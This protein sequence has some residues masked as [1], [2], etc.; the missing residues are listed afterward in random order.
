MIEARG[1]F[2]EATR[3]NFNIESNAKDGGSFILHPRALIFMFIVRITSGMGNAIPIFASS[4]VELSQDTW[5]SLSDALTVSDSDGDLVQSIRFENTDT[6]TLSYSVSM[7]GYLENNITHELPSLED[8]YVKSSNNYVEEAIRI[9]LYDG[10]EWG[11]WTTFNLRNGATTTNIQ[12]RKQSIQ[13][14]KRNDVMVLKDQAET[15]EE[16]LALLMIQ[17]AAKR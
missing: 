15:I 16:G 6:E 1:Y 9:Q 2:G 8:V 7:G 17:V 14:W 10:Y 4:T 13:T 3:Y 12:Q 5:T 11:D